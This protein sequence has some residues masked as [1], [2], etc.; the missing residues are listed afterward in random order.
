MFSDGVKRVLR[1]REMEL[2]QVKAAVEQTSNSVSTLTSDNHQLKQE[3]AEASETISGLEES[4]EQANITIEEL[5]KKLEHLISE[6]DGLVAERSGLEARTRQLLGKEKSAAKELQE[7]LDGLTAQYNAVQE[8][9]VAERNRALELEQRLLTKEEE[10]ETLIDE[11]KN[12][13]DSALSDSQQDTRETL[14][15]CLEG[16]R[17]AVAKLTNT[18]KAKE[19][20]LT[21]AVDQYLQ[22]KVSAAKSK[23]EVSA[24]HSRIRELTQEIT[25]LKSRNEQMISKL[26]REKQDIKDKLESLQ[27]QL[28]KVCVYNSLV[29]R[30]LSTVGII[31][32]LLVDQQ[33]AW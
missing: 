22:E 1:E 9:A 21:N 28:H 5:R 8:R 2:A 13:N 11:R 19:A 27:T 31:F 26:N 17:A 24:L 33:Q 15:K 32:S 10:F 7:R 23:G 25:L 6:K 16:E 18:L 12:R 30:V 29:H 4:M 20:E 3:L 14:L